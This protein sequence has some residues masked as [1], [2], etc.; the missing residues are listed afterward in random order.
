MRQLSVGYFIPHV[1]TL[2]A[3]FRVNIDLIIWQGIPD[4][5]RELNVT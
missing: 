4:F 3:S 2:F 1:Y 5:F